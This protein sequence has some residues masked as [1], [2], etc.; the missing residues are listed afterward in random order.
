MNQPNE[1]EVVS[2]PIRFDDYDKEKNQ[3]TVDE[4]CDRGFF[5]GLTAL[6]L[7]CF[8]I[9]SVIAI[10]FGV[11]GQRIMSAANN[12]ADAYGLSLP[13]KYFIGKSFSIVGKIVG[14]VMTAFWT[15][16][17][18]VMAATVWFVVS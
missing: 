7:C 3:K 16:W 4:K 2:E 9:C 11:S 12:L 1:N 17:M 5:K 6:I 18:I 8:P 13:P 10:C 14:I 15:I